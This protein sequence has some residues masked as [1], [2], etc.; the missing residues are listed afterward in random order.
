MMQ[1]IDG[2]VFMTLKMPNFN[3]LTRHKLLPLCVGIVDI[4]LISVH[5]YGFS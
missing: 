3:P 2:Q 4:E 5:N 1:L